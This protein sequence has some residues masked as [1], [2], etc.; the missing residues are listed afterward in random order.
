MILKK[1]VTICGLLN[2]NPTYLRSCVFE[3][4]AI[5]IHWVKNMCYINNFTCFNCFSNSEERFQLKYL[6]LDW[7][8]P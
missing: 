7:Y 1:C 5:E 8:I 4:N 6:I 2:E 3:I